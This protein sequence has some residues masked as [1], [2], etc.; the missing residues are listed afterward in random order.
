MQERESYRELILENIEYDYLIQSHQLDRDRLDELVELM[1][2][3]Y[4]NKCGCKFHKNGKTK[5]GVQK[6]ICSGC[7]LTRS[8]TTNTVIYY[9]KLSFE[10]WSNIIDNLLDG[11][12]LRRIAEERCV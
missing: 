5:N 11:F 12:S 3:L 4:C 6:Y 2:D 7:K 8:E 1:G 10:I 9:S